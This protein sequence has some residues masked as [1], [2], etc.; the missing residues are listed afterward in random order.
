MV[1]TTCPPAALAHAVRIVGSGIVAGDASIRTAMGT[2]AESLAVTTWS[3]PCC[4]P[5]RNGVSARH[6]DDC[7]VGATGSAIEDP[8]SGTQRTVASRVR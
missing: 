7:G 4:G 2:R 5:A 8:L 3:A 1:D 6:V